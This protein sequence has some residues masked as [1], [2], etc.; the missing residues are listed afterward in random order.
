MK[1]VVS[2]EPSGSRKVK[3]RRGG[4]WASPWPP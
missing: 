3:E 4:G 2:Q 1:M